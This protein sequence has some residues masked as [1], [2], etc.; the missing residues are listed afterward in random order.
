MKK[1]ISRLY[2]IISEKPL[3]LVVCFV[4]LIY[5]LIYCLIW[6]QRGMFYDGVTYTAVASNLYHGIGNVRNPLFFI[7]QPN[8]HGSAIFSQYFYEHPVL[9]FMLDSYLF[10]LIG[11][12]EYV[13]K[14]I[15]I[16][17]WFCQF[18]LLVLL[19]DK[20]KLK[21]KDLNITKSSVI[22]L[23]LTY[24]TTRGCLTT[25]F[26]DNYLTTFVMLGV[27]FYLLMDSSRFLFV[28]T[29]YCALATLSILL[30]VLSNGPTALAFLLTIPI[31]NFN[32]SKLLNSILNFVYPFVLFLV[33]LL[34]VYYLYPDIILNF[35]DYLKVQLFPSLSGGE[36]AIENS[37][38]V[39]GVWSRLLWFVYRIILI[40]NPIFILLTFLFISGYSKVRINYKL[41][42]LF[43]T[44][45]VPIIL[46]T[47]RSTGALRFF[48]HSFFILAIIQVAFIRDLIN[49]AKYKI[50]L[51]IY[52]KWFINLFLM[53]SVLLFVAIIYIVSTGYTTRDKEQ[54]YNLDA[55][56]HIKDNDHSYICSEDSELVRN[57]NMQSYLI[58][59]LATN[60]VYEK[61]CDYSKY[62]LTRNPYKYNNTHD[63]SITVLKGNLWFINNNDYT[64]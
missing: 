21:F 31:L 48:E 12:A 51:I 49:G 52:K 26:C 30:A 61:K 15:L 2:Q 10:D 25:N 35:I 53:L 56:A 9:V 23:W 1:Q 8:I 29:V 17:N 45:S 47:P 64:K 57:T 62:I 43:L 42:V 46:F 36:R 13:D 50:N 19:V 54:I 44:V 32:K 39:M 27:L 18:I 14:I 22:L 16:L 28:K 63:Y 40:D 55:I 4:V 5:C 7:Y 6:A 37:H 34:M 33:L 60:I 11:N 58:R 3:C 41:C 38:V 59:Y 24:E 20:L